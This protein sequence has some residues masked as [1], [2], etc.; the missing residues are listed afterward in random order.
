M[1]W[2]KKKTMLLDPP[3]DLFELATKLGVERRLN[4]RVRYV[5]SP[6]QSHLKF[7]LCKLPSVSLGDKFLSVH[8][9]STG[10][11]CLIDSDNLLGSKIGQEVELNLH[12][13][14]GRE[15]VRCKIV[16]G[17]N[18]RRHVQFVNLS[19]TRQALLKKF[20]YPGI[21]GLAIWRHGTGGGENGPVLVADE[22]WSSLHG[23]SVTVERDVHLVATLF[24]MGEH[25]QIFREAWPRKG[26]GRSCSKPE[27]EQLILFLTNIPSPSPMLEQIRED[28][29]RQLDRGAS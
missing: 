29:L 16:A 23:D 6:L 1:F 14:T 27:L 2:R 3:S 22:L 13:T 5:P 8:D 10:G 4:S 7:P 25:Y 17:V 20:M 11:C 24:F 28:L 18:E 19:E 21:R 26:Q 9:I 15:Q 12:W